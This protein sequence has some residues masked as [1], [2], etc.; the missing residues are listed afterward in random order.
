MDLPKF[1]LIVLFVCA[2][3]SSARAGDT[4]QDATATF[5][6]FATDRQAALS[7]LTSCE[8]HGTLSITVT[9]EW[10]KTHP[11]SIA[12]RYYKFT[13]IARDGKLKETI[14]LLNNTGQPGETK[15]YYLNAKQVIEIQSPTPDSKPIQYKTFPLSKRGSDTPNGLFNECPAFLEYAFLGISID[16]AGIPALLP[17]DIA[18]KDKWTAALQALKECSLD[19]N[20]TLHARLSDTN[21]S[22]TVDLSKLPG[23]DYTVTAIT[24][25]TTDKHL[26]RK[27]EASDL[28]HDKTVGDMP[29]TF[30]IGVYRSGDDAPPPIIWKF[31]IED[32]K[33]NIPIDDASLTPP[34]APPDDDIP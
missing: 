29:T 28:I 7:K 30:S 20:N 26:D 4:P 31:K 23:A 11:R 10:L 17:S 9:P 22:C 25:L 21:G 5:K 12:L 13:I 24:F 2:F 18:S 27:I 33:F 16:F 3:L 34:P 8:I 19:K 14:S 6:Q 15:T 32:I 1:A